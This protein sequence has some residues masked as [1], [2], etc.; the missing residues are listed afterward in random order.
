MKRIKGL[1]TAPFTAFT[2]DNKIDLSMVGRQQKMYKEN[3]IS[4]VF[5]CGSTGEGPALTVQEKKALFAE[6]AKYNEPD[7][8][9]I[10]FLGGTSVEECRE[11]A[12]YAAEC[13]LDA[14]A[15]TAPYYFKP[16][17]IGTLAV[18]CKQI[19]DAVP[20][21]PFFYYHIPVLTGVNFPMIELLKAMDGMIPNLAGIKY[22]YENMMDFQFCLNFKDR[23]YNILWGRDEMLL[24]ALSI[25][26]VGAVGSTYGYNAPI[27]NRIIE[28]FR[29][30]NIEQAAAL[31]LTAND[32]ISLLGKYGGGTGKA[33]MKAIGMDMG[34]CR[35]PINSLTD[36]QYASLIEDL[37]AVPFREHCCKVNR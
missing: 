12:Q 4:G 2:S 13:K 33:F 15:A 27:Y 26:A 29:S 16:A 22:T 19:A 8:H 25:G 31:Q 5:I 18:F 35:A 34:G 1:I 7:F 21:T 14:V 37:K 30:G 11:L 10:A 23:K 6:W 36:A 3:G 28:L 20:E 17:D 24:P 32:F 9:I